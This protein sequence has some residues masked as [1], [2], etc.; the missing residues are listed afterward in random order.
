MKG[1]N[2]VALGEIDGALKAHRMERFNLGDDNQ[3]GGLASN[4]IPKLLRRRLENADVNDKEVSFEELEMYRM[5][6]RLEQLDDSASKRLQRTKCRS[7][8]GS[9]WASTMPI[10]RGA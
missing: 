2:L 8:F 10:K 1:Y 5:L 4:E 3:D 7:D 9:D 6:T